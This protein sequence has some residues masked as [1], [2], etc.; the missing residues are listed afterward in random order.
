[1]VHDESGYGPR[2]L[3][4]THEVLTDM[5]KRRPAMVADLLTDLFQLEV[6]PWERATDGAA[7]VTDIKPVQLRA[8]A[9]PVFT[10]GAKKVLAV[11][12]EVQ[13]SENPAKRRTW[14]HYLTS[15]HRRLKCP[16]MLLVICHDRAVARWSA[17]PITVGHPGWV[18]RPLVLGPDQ[19]PVI[20]DPDQAART[21]ELAVLSAMAHGAG[22]EREQVFHAMLTA[23]Q[24]VDQESFELYTD[25]VLRQLPEATQHFLEA[26]VDLATYEF[27]SNYWRGKLA[28]AEAKAQAA[29]RAAGEAAMVLEVLA[30]RD[31]DVPAGARE[32]ITACTDL[33]QLRAW[34]RRAA[35]ADSIEDLFS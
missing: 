3:S 28:E 23:L 24:D 10:H 11:V 31:V 9:V 8:D 34:A 4:E 33:D 22:P 29:G 19:V 26:M 18:L 35:T 15:L 16:T 13:L 5:V 21:P 27:K 12:C 30:A 2:V 14:P 17:K 1:V 25:M 20:T 7:E 32:H 6:P